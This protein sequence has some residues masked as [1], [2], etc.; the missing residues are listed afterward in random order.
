MYWVDYNPLRPRFHFPYLIG[1]LGGVVN[2][3]KCGEEGAFLKAETGPIRA[4]KSQI[5]PSLWSIPYAASRI[6]ARLNTA[7]SQSDYMLTTRE[8]NIVIRAWYAAG[9]SQADLARQFGISYQ[10]VHQIIHGRR[11]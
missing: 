10:R 3:N 11:K 4:C 1:H 9:V 8:R 2:G 6:L 7:P 5:A